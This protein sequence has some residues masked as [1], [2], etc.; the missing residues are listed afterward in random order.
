MSRLGRYFIAR[1]RAAKFHAL[2]TITMPL[3][4][5]IHLLLIFIAI[6]GSGLMAGIR[7]IASKVA[8]GQYFSQI[9]VIPSGLES[10][11]LDADL[12]RLLLL[13]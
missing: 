3:T 13:E 2:G 6:V 12:G 9:C 4:D 1:G 10:F 7:A 5:Q 8:S 11:G